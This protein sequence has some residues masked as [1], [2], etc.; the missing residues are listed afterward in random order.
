VKGKASIVATFTLGFVFA[1]CD[2]RGAGI[3]DT[4]H[5]LSVSGPGPIKAVAEEQICIFCHTPHN[6][7]RDIPYLWNR[8]DTTVNYT[9]YESTTLYATV[10]QPSGA[11]KMCLSCH[12]G[13]IALGAVLSRPEEIPFAGGIRFIPEGVT[14]LGTDI[15]DDHPV[16][17]LYDENLALT[18]DELVSPSTLINEVKLDK[19]G[20]LQCTSCHN[21][22]DNTYGKFQVMS[23]NYS[24]LCTACHD[25]MDW[26]IS[27]HAIS[28]ATWNGAGINPWPHTPFTT[29]DENGC[30]NCHRP[31]TAGGHARLL[32]YAIEEDN[33]LVCHNANV[34]STDIEAELIKQYRH[35][36]QDYIGVHNPAEDF[37]SLV[38]AHVECVDCHNPHR[39]NDSPASAPDIPGPLR[40]V[41][42][43]TASGAPV[44]EAINGY[45]VCFK[46]HADN[47][48]LSLSEISR[49]NQQINTRLEFDITNPSYHPVEGVGQNP[50]V[51]SLLFP[52]TVSSIIYCTDCHNSDDNPANGGVGPKG[53]H[54]S[55]NKY[56]LERNYTTLDSTLE[57]SFEYALCYKCHDRNSILN[58]ESFSKHTKHIV[59]EKTPCSACHDPHGVSAT[60]GNSVNNSHLINF[61]VNI[62][63]PNSNG[64]LQFEDLG[65]FQGRCFL[66]CHS[67][68]HNPKEY[69]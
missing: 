13:T 41:K 55:V 19:S 1:V 35:A 47:N 34:A 58:D 22:H 40:G 33:C 7:R 42:G 53:P 61:D 16:S 10:G 27:A 36:V 38:S 29:V 50:D 25:R 18:S 54:G 9:T 4:T 45:E 14:K 57:T 8:Q 21:P 60:Q 43:I 64:L 2:L 37:P 15:S 11:S 24:A 44:A 48:V 69:P 39:A 67:K 32:N 56:I 5:N 20:L 63:S 49:Q 51:P 3:A 12:D 68:D 65:R 62:V 23:N 30:E 6:A 52:Y 28:N 59:D 66:S 26:G 31:H 46:C 17:F